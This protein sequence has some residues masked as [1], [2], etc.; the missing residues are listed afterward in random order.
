MGK[1]ASNSNCHFVGSHNLH[2]F[3][4]ECQKIKCLNGPHHLFHLGPTVTLPIPAPL[5]LATTLLPK[6]GKY[7]SKN[8]LLGFLLA[9]SLHHMWPSST[10][11]NSFRCGCFSSSW[12]ASNCYAP[13]LSHGDALHLNV[14]H[15]D[16]VHRPHGHILHHRCNHFQLLAGTH[17]HLPPSDFQLCPSKSGTACLIFFMVILLS[18]HT[19]F[20]DPF[21]LPLVSFWFPVVSFWCRD[22][23]SHILYGYIS[24]GHT[25]FSDSFS[26]FSLHWIFML[27]RQPSS[28]QSPVTTSIRFRRARAKTRDKIRLTIA[29]SALW[30][31][32]H[33]LW[34]FLTVALFRLVH[35]GHQKGFSL[36]P[37]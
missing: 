10:P 15:C 28:P 21:S 1:P 35:P 19:W 29:V 6:W 11:G 33:H 24:S 12:Y 9:C 37:T 27:H 2:N 22:T 23:V 3:P 4:A 32:I 25:W 7:C 17:C 16:G 18:G 20:S 8:G 31:N 14:F 36:K 13:S 34:T 26:F 5:C 30:T